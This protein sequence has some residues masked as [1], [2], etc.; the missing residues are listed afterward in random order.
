MILL[1][2]FV[3][4]GVTL[5]GILSL[6]IS[7]FA[8][9]SIFKTVHDDI[10]KKQQY[11]Y[12]LLFIVIFN[13]SLLF[14]L[15]LATIFYIAYYTHAFPGE[16]NTMEVIQKFFMLIKSFFE[17]RAYI[18]PLMFLILILLNIILIVFYIET[19]ESDN[20]IFEK[21]EENEEDEDIDNDKNG[22]GFV[23]RMV[24]LLY[25]IDFSILLFSVWIVDWL[26]L[27]IE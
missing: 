9:L 7:K 19:K 26:R 10:T 11:M 13:L 25:K 21:G 3:N 14:I 12:S 6:W 17:P 23:Y 15:V 27:C 2:L 8:S 16:H 22:I 18:L 5:Y 20:I 4:I 1:K 24:E